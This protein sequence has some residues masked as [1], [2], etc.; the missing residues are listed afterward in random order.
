METESPSQKTMAVDIAREEL[1][2]KG[3]LEKTDY[4][5][6]GGVDRADELC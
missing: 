6:D 3:I 2:D 5:I 4:D 1:L